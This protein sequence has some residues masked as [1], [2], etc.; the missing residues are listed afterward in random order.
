M[1]AQKHT[2]PAS[3]L[4]AR[5][6]AQGQEL[7]RQM[8][9]INTEG[10]AWNNER[11]MGDKEKRLRTDNNNNNNKEFI[12]NPDPTPNPTTYSICTVALSWYQNIFHPY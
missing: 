10:S 2:T 7:H 12:R 4:K 8:V 1:L 6:S 9:R 3:Y 11:T 5:C